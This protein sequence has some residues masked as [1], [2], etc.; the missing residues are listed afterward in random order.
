MVQVAGSRSRPFDCVECDDTTPFCFFFFF[1]VFPGS[2]FHPESQVQTG[3]RS[4]SVQTPGLLHDANTLADYP[5][6]QWVKTVA[7]QNTSLLL[8]RRNTKN[9]LP[10]LYPAHAYSILVAHPRCTKPKLQPST[11]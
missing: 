6:I 10:F 2:G 5:K 11:N 3:Y 4:C 9:H 7:K 8:Q 1:V